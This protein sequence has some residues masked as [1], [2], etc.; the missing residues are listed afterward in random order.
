MTRDLTLIDENSWHLYIIECRTKELY[1]GICKN[2]AQRIG[3]HN[4]GRATR[5]TK[6]RIPVKLFYS[7][8]CGDY[9]SARKRERI[10]KK[11]SREKKM[12]LAEKIMT[13]HP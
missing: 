1:V 4:T 7:E 6:Y 3:L 5:Y 13:S 12:A 11:F 2:V 8:F 10:V 9:G